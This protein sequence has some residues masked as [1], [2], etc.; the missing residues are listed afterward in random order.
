MVEDFFVSPAYRTASCVTDALAQRH[1]Q[2]EH[3]HQARC[4]SLFFKLSIPPLGIPYNHIP[5][6]EPRA[7]KEKKKARKKNYARNLRTD[8][9]FIHKSYL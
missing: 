1:T 4:P 3:D 7:N 6:I 9:Y 5:C 8:P 2:P